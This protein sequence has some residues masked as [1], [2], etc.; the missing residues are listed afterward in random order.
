MDGS[1]QNTSSGHIPCLVSLLPLSWEAGP[2]GTKP[3]LQGLGF[4]KTIIN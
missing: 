4:G 3:T 2:Q 1:I